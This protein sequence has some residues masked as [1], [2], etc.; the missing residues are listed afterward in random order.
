MAIGNLLDN[1]RKYTPES[2]VITISVNGK[3][4]SVAVEVADTGVG[5][6]QSEQNEIFDRFKRANN[7]LTSSVEGTGLG[8]YLARRIVELHNGSI[9]VASKKGQGSK[10]TMVLPLRRA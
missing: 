1:A 10:F 7:M 5:I 2:G 3:R 4:G 6:D 8:L 9:N